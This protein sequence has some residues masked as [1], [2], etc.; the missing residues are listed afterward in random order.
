M[1]NI[2]VNEGTLLKITEIDKEINR[3]D[4]LKNDM[5]YCYLDAL[6]VDFLSKKVTLDIASKKIIIE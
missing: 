4:R 3:L 2:T 5:I 1:E 6:N